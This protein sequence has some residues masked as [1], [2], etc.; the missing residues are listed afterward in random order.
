MRNISPSGAQFY[1]VTKDFSV[2]HSSWAHEGQMVQVNH[3]MSETGNPRSAVLQQSLESTGCVAC[4][5][6]FGVIFGTALCNING[7]FLMKITL[8]R[9]NFCII[10]AFPIENIE[11]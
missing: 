11:S 1:R 10:S 2:G 3:I 9:G 6:I 5:M 8:F 4:G 7:T